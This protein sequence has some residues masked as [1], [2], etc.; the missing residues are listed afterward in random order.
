CCRRRR[1]RTAEPTNLRSTRER[2][3]A[4]LLSRSSSRTSQRAA[5][6]PELRRARLQPGGFCLSGLDPLATCLTL[7]GVNQS[8]DAWGLG[9]G[10]VAGTFAHEHA[11]RL[12]AFAPSPRV[13]IKLS[14]G[15]R[16]SRERL[17]SRPNR[18]SPFELVLNSTSGRES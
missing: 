6:A 16:R 1:K 2:P 18:A 17:L 7:S 12:H 5:G 8:H 3:R 13:F 10:V 4:T 15:A 14:R 11:R 9:F